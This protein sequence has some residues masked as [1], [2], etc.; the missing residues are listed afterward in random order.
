MYAIRISMKV[1][2]DCNYSICIDI[3]LHI[4]YTDSAVISILDRGH[5]KCHFKFIQSKIQRKLLQGQSNSNSL[6][7]KH[8]SPRRCPPFGGSVRPCWY[9]SGKLH[10]Y[11]QTLWPLTHCSVRYL[12]RDSAWCTP[13]RWRRRHTFQPQGTWRLQYS[14][15]IHHQHSR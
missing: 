6:C 12:P 9:Q 8:V 10:Y 4:P 5:D 2:I 7:Q 15:C 3:P 11:D 13:Q 1:V 14:G